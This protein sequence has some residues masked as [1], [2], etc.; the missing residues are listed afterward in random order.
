[1]YF[2]YTIFYILKKSIVN[3]TWLI[4]KNIKNSLRLSTLILI[5]VLQYTVTPLVT[6]GYSIVIDVIMVCECGCEYDNV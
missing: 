2:L 5:L 4:L 6:L 3:Y 1:M